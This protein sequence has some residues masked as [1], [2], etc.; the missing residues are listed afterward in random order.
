MKNVQI[1]YDAS[2]SRIAACAL[3]LIS[4]FLL[5][6]ITLLLCYLQVKSLVSSTLTAVQITLPR[7]SIR[8]STRSFQPLKMIIDT[9]NLKECCISYSWKMFKF[10]KK[11]L[12][13]DDESYSRIASCAL[14]L[15]STFLLSQIT[16]LLCYLQVKSLV[17]STLTAVQITR[18]F[19]PLKMI[20]DTS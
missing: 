17:S 9:S 4:T 14:N 5:S 20:I 16:L 15:I 3:N 6:Q 10:Y 12:L 18:S 2:D 8:A 13:P 7:F 19:Q 1:Y 11:K